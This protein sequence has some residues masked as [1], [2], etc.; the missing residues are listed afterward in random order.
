M[1]PLP[2]ETEGRPSLAAAPWNPHPW[3]FSRKYELLLP[4]V[5]ILTLI[6]TSQDRSLNWGENQLPFSIRICIQTTYLGNVC[7]IGLHH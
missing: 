6:F 3:P 1:S 5:P 4:A 2:G 7:G